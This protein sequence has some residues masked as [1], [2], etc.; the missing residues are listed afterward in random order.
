MEGRRLELTFKVVYICE[1]LVLVSVILALVLL[2]F[3][4]VLLAS[5]LLKTMLKRRHA[6][7]LKYTHSIIFVI[8]LPLH[9]AAAKEVI[10]RHSLEPGGL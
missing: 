1:R 9:E 3:L 6:D 4:H 10:H 7:T 8:A 2:I 5:T